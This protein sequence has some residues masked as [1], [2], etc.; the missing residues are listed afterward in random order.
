M[1]DAVILSAARTPIARSNKGSLVDVD[2]F[3]LAEIAVGAALARAGVP[4][5]DIDDLILGESLQGGGVIARHTALRLDL[6]GTPGLADNRH[7]AA[8]LS[9]VQIAASGIRAGMDRLVI[10]GGTESLSSMPRVFKS[11]PASRQDFVPW[12]SPSHPETADAPSFDMSITVGENSARI[13]KVTRQ[14]A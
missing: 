6:V 12:M 3:V 14:E 8:G 13:G 9:A 7:C 10:A 11:Q 4:S 1:T 2:A 5:E